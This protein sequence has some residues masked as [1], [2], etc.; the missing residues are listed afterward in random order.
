MSTKPKSVKMPKHRKVLRDNIQGITK[1]ALL[2][3]ARRAGVKRMSGLCYDELRKLILKKL[4]T[5]IEKSMTFTEIAKRKKLMAKDVR[6]AAE[7]MGT[8]LIG[9][10]GQTTEN[11]TTVVMRPKKTKSEGPAKK[12]HK[13][14][15]GTVAIRE[16]K[17]HQKGK[18]CILIRRGPFKRLVREVMQNY[19]VDRQLSTEA[20]DLLQQWIEQF[21][22][23]LL[24]DA[25][26]EAIH[27]KRQEV[28]SKDI[29]LVLR[30]MGERN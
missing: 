21:L 26:L 12:P 28:K 6:A 9:F 13:F 24:E 25:N 20:S 10:S 5:I 23:R 15:P 18:G 14:H 7:L 3:I 4:E 2:R 17:H 19:S 16:I 22:L 30:I 29:Q 27:A 1:P 8:S 11:L